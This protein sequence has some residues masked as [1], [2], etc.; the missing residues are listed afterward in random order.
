VRFDP[1]QRRYINEQGHPLSPAQVRKEVNDYITGEKE[2]TQAKA[3]QLLN[4][5]ISLTSFFMYLKTRVEAWHEVAGSIAYGGKAQLDPERRA[6][7]KAK[8][9]SE[10]KYLREFQKQAKASFEAARKIASSVASQLEAEPIKS[11]S[12]KLTVS[13]RAKIQKRV[14]EDLLEA[15]PSE[16]EQVT[17]NAV[18]AV[19]EGIEARLIAESISVATDQAADLIGGTIPTRAGMYA[20]AA[21]STF[22]NNEAAREFDSGVRLGRRVCEEDGSSCDE[23]V[24]AA[25]TFFAPLDELPEIGSLQC[26]NNCRCFFEYAEP[27]ALTLNAQPLVDRLSAEMVQ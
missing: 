14:F 13:M 4:G 15:N 10:L 12:G 22:Q 21:Y 6:R 19:L 24:D 1:K 20:D 18:N 16:A 17:R 26:I 7:I 3:Q 8:T 23:C 27:D 11:F 2:Q 25:D 5:N 9:D